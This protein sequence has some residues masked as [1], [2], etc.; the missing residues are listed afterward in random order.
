M[1]KKDQGW[2]VQYTGPARLPE[3]VLP[4]IRTEQLQYVFAASSSAGGV[5]DGIA[6]TATSSSVRSNGAD[7]PDWAQLFRE[8]RVRSLLLEYHPNVVNATAA[9]PVLYS[10]VFTVI[11]RL[12]TSSVAAFTNIVSNTSMEIFALDSEWSRET[13]AISTGEADFTATSSD[14]TKFFAVKVFSTGLSASATYGYF[15]LRWVVEFRTRD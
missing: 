7:F 9:A 11:D 1:G 3:K 15:L 8:Y 5:L 13:K 12:D 10:P 6:A 2:V 4:E 14:P